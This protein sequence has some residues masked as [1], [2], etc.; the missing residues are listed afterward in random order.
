M[1]IQRYNQR[2][3]ILIHNLFQLFRSTLWFHWSKYWQGAKQMTNHSI[4]IFFYI[5]YD[6]LLRCSRWLH[7]MGTVSMLFA[8]CEGN[9]LRTDWS[10]SQRANNA[11][12]CVFLVVSLNTIE[13]QVN[14]PVYFD[15]MRSMWCH[16]NALVHH[17]VTGGPCV[18]L[19]FGLASDVPN[20]VTSRAFWLFL[21]L[22]SHLY[23]LW[24]T[25]T[26][27]CNLKRNQNQVH[28]YA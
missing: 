17:C 12:L 13:Q 21:I 6:A 7:V 26:S 3:S 23:G 20:Y 27:V 28:F 22:I 24:T 11:R 8:L 18:L 10:P 15:V 19:L 1:S 16:C 2:I 5:Y 4:N 9:P 14:C 25:T